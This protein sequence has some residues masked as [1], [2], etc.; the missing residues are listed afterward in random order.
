MFR[1]RKIALGLLVTV[2]VALAVGT[3]HIL[4]AGALYWAKS[5]ARQTISK[6][7]PEE[8]RILNVTPVAVELPSTQLDSR[9]LDTVEIGGYV[10]WIPRPTTHAYTP[11][12]KSIILTYPQYQAIIRA[13]FSIAPNDAL[14]KQLHFKDWFD[15]TSATYHA[16][17]DDLDAQRDLSSVRRFLFLIADK[18]NLNP[19]RE[20]FIRGD[21]RGFIFDP[22]PTDKRTVVEIFLPK[23]QTGLGVWIT[24]RDVTRANV[25]DF[26]SVLQIHPKDAEKLELIP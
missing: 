11:S 22:I 16:R 26:L 8:R 12:G 23:S 9:L 17:L 4:R 13:P 7:T 6:F 1:S 2:L 18:P 24:G 20:E 15:Q 5:S 10:F 21:L 19:C 3:P 14:A 25:H